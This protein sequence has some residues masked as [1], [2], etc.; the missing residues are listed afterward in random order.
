MT[1]FFRP[2]DFVAASAG[3]LPTDVPSFSR[4]ALKNGWRADR[5]RARI[6]VDQHGGGWVYHY[7]LAPIEVQ[8]RLLALSQ[9]EAAPTPAKPVDAPSKPL[10]QLFEGLPDKA[11][12]EATRRLA[13]VDRIETLSRASIL[14]AA[15]AIVS[16]ETDVSPSTLYNW[17]AAARGVP[18]ADRLAALAPRRQGRTS[19]AEC[20]PRAWDFIVADYLRAEKT[21]F[22]PCYRRMQEVAKREGWSP[23]PHPKTLKRRLE[24]EIPVSARIAVRQGPEALKRMYPA[25]K[26]DRT[27]FGPLQSVNIDGHKLDVFVKLPNADTPV[28]VIL[29]AIQDLGTGLYVG[30]NL[31]LAETF[32]SVRLAVAD[33]VENY[34]IPE[35]IY[36]DNGKAFA[37]KLISGQQKTRF[38]FRIKEDEP[39]GVLTQLGIET[40]WTTPYSGQSKPIE[41]SFRDLCEEIAKHPLCAGAYTGNSPTNKPH[42]YGKAAIPLADLEAL[43]EHEIDRHNAREGRRGF[44]MNGRSFLQVWNDK[45]AAG[46]MVRRGTEEQRRML[47][48]ASKDVMVR[49]DQPAIHFYENRYWAEELIQYAG[50]KVM[51]KF[52]PRQLWAPLAVYSLDGRFV[53]SADCI[54]MTGFDDTDAARSHTKLRTG[55]M[56]A[57]KRAAELQ[58]RLSLRE[59]Q[60]LVTPSKPS[61]IEPDQ[62]KVVRLVAA[63]GGMRG[64]IPEMT[65]FDAA[66]SA[67]VAAL[68]RDADVLPFRR[69]GN[70]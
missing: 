59:L 66:F 63:A 29:V 62:P 22:E 12:A 69:D 67:G 3:E 58:Q 61:S 24:K 41:R 48:L 44:G 53:C 55:W 51:V 26:R 31:D 16:Q 25:Q 18:R 14:G 20:D 23:I 9:P 34:G 15:V 11:K 38:R 36:L 4:Y 17:L 42:N 10:W 19:T 60:A 46:A 33:M 13:A 1:E 43:V 32:E 2:S 45:I 40:H 21:A 7:S 8:N 28:R 5:R 47:L 49:R 35:S 68:D 70:E 64:P 56:K 52:D 30:W 39:L 50:K 27:H 57:Q 37:S 65:D 54:E 6:A